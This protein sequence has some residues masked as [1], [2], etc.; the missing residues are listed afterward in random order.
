MTADK[1]DYRS[2]QCEAGAMLLTEDESRKMKAMM[3]LWLMRDRIIAMLE[4]DNH[5]ALV[6]EI[7]SVVKEP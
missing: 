6:D 1:L 7:K 2:F 5:K 3:S 4:R